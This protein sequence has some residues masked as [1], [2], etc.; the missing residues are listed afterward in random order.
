MTFKERLAKIKTGLVAAAKAFKKFMTTQDEL[1]RRLQV[2]VT[3]NDLV[4]AEK[5]ILNGA[6]VNK[7]R[8]S[9]EGPLPDAVKAGQGEMVA[10]LLKH[11]ADPNHKYGYSNNTPLWMA[12]RQGDMGIITQLLEAG[13]DV[14]TRGDKDKTVYTFAVATKNKPLADVLLARGAKTDTKDKF[15]WTPLFYAARNGDTETVAALLQS[16][17]RTYLKDCE[18]RSVLRVAADAEQF[19]ARDMIQSHIDAQVPSWQKVSD[20]EIAHVSI[21]RQ[22]GYRLTETFNMETKTC[23][24]IAHNFA[25]G[26]DAVVVQSF[27]ELKNPLLVKTATEKLAGLTPA[28]EQQNTPAKPTAAPAAV[29]PGK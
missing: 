13:G 21:F 20:Q 24:V 10:L 26:K 23:A 25:T 8:W 17:S 18:G 27:D 19:A 2:A 22:Q 29:K 14:N 9:E 4:R 11:K 12:V 1:D 3:A 28:A 16:G 15:G 6:D 7:T 5:A